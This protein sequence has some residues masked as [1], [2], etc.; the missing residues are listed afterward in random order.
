MIS[1]LNLSNNI[2]K[3]SFEDDIDVTPMKLQKLIFLVYKEYLKKTKMPL[4]GERFAVWKYGPVVQTVYDQFKHR[5][6]NAI[7]EYAKDCNGTAKMIDESAPTPF[8]EVLDY[9]WNKYKEID[10]IALSGMTHQ[11]GTAWDKAR[12]SGKPYLSDDDIIAEKEY[13]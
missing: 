3:R 12:K 8:K 1:A 13:L 5:K 9:V 4:F 6:A 11:E 7:R 2:L 10:G